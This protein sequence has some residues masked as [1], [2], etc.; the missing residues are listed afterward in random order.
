MDFILD[1]FDYVTGFFD[2]VGE[3]FESVG[4]FFDFVGEF[5]KVGIYD[6]IVE[7]FAE[8]IIWSQIQLIYFKMW[9]LGFAYDIAQEMIAQLNVSAFI[10]QAWSSLGSKIVNLLTFFKVPTAINIILSARV[11][12]FVLD[13]LSF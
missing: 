10:N 7:A 4:E 9:T 11:T 1:F 13:L 8:F 6:L 2:F 12:R 5:I 3:F